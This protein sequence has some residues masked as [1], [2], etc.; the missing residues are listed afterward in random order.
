MSLFRAETEQARATAWLGRVVLVRPLSFGILTAVALAITAT[1][2]L[3]FIVGDYTRKARVTGS[4]APSEGLVRVVAQQ[5]GRVQD[6]GIVEGIEVAR[7][8]HLLSV[9]DARAN[10][11]VPQPA[12][13]SAKGALARHQA[14]T[15]QQAFIGAAMD[16]EQAAYGQRLSGLARELD[17]LE[18]ELAA[19][20]QRVRLAERSF[21]RLN[22]LREVGFVSAIA[23]DRERESALDQQ[24]RLEALQR[25]RIALARERDAIAFERAS[26]LARSR[27]Q[28][29]GVDLQR[30][31]IEQERM[32]TE[33][34]HRIDIVA[35]APGV[36]AT[37]LVEPG[38]AV[39]VGTTL[40]TII[41]AGAPLEAH[42]YA[43]SRSIG[44]VRPGQD[45]LL[46]Y[47]AYPH[48]KFGTHRGRV[49]AISR[50]AVSPAE[51]GATTADGREPVYR[52]K[53]E[54]PAQAIAAY[55]RDEPLKAGMQVEADIL[56]DRR[57]L[58]EWIF[59]PLLGLAGRA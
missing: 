36:V 24:G 41:P 47:P 5:P 18:R 21:E 30:A 39:S 16:A 25:S 46:R 56:L 17:Q 19:Q 6:L 2:A 14:L 59:E 22:E 53:V 3:Y 10:E 37:V 32:E 38:Q 57:R 7:D 43:P 11:F 44:F 20:K 23:V 12:W 52:I 58:I 40:A 26:A 51:L 9:V 15:R 28:M 13:S 54:L 35:P 4:L 34:R 1:A 42:L 8:E 50:S 49:A 29:A 45:V 31:V 48:Q 33:L 27:A 55:G